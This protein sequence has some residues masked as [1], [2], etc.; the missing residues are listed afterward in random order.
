MVR[1]SISKRPRASRLPHPLDRFVHNVAIVRV[2]AG[3]IG[4]VGDLR[5]RRDAE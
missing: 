2:H 3:E 5:F 1:Y 4:F